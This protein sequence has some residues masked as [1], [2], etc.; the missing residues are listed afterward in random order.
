MPDLR[1]EKEIGGTVAGVD[2]VGR[3]PWAGP[4]VAAAVVLRPDTPLDG[5]AD[6]KK[7]SPVRRRALAARLH[8]TADVSIAAASVEEI[9]SLNIL[10]ATGLG[11]IRAVTGLSVA[12]DHVLIDG[13]RIPKDCR[14]PATAVIGGDGRSASIAAASICAKVYRDDLM[15]RLDA[16]YPGYGWAR[17]A[18]YGTREHREALNRLGPCPEHRKSFRPIREILT[19]RIGITS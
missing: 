1:M 19:Q 2:E 16:T 10:E 4:V 9:D 12:P 15:A 17:N 13:N 8:E 18:G 6:S 11:M 7:L 5:I 3:G 14:W